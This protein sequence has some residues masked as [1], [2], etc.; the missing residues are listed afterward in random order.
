MIQQPPQ[1]HSCVM[2]RSRPKQRGLSQLIG[3]SFRSLAEGVATDKGRLRL[4]YA[5]LPIIHP[6]IRNAE[7][8]EP[9][10]SLCTNTSGACPAFKVPSSHSWLLFY[11]VHGRFKWT[12][13][14]KTHPTRDK[15]K[16]FHIGS[17]KSRR[18]R[19]FRPIPSH[20]T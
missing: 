19:P 1:L 8:G 6:G 3:Q 12:L 16:G 5:R 15:C 20:S 4:P 9:R 14:R 17:L 7:N 18:W 2:H 13:T 11:A 10:P